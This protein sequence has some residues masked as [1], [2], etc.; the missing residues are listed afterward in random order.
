MSDKI[1]YTSEVER[2]DLSKPRYDQNSYIGRAKHFFNVCDPTTVFAS[3]K[4]LEKAQELIL[5]YKNGKEPQKTSMEQL[6]SAKKL[7]DSAFHPDTGEKL[8]LIGRMSFQVPGNMFIV[9]GMLSF[10]KGTSAVIFWQFLNQ[11]FN[12]IV[13]YTNR[14]ATST[15]TND[16]LAKAYLAA[17]TSAVATAL[18][19]NYLIARSPFLSSG[20]LG[21]FVPLFSM[22]AANCVNLPL[23]RQTELQQGID[24]TDQEGNVI[25]KSQ[26]AARNSIIKVIA[27]RI[28]MSVPSAV[29]PPIIMASLER[30]YPTLKTAGA[31]RTPIMMSLV[32]ANLVFSTPLCCA[33]FP[34]QDSLAVEK[35]EEKFRNLKTLS[36][37]PITHIFFNKGL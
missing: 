14:N 3:P 23:M 29:I 11:T 20:M 16:D 37:Q 18:S 1:V 25:G 36:G 7:Y 35:A 22:A 28:G 9:G 4:E 24:V 34:Q 10:Y 15:L 19:L 5:A 8:L 13:N 31:I 30:Y 6:W 17:S 33:L 32:G 12:A 2:V 21:R 26:I 27:S